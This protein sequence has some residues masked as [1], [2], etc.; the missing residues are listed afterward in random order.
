MKTPNAFREYRKFLVA[1]I[2]MA[3]LS[4]IGLYLPRIVKAGSAWGEWTVWEIRTMVG[5]APEGLEKTAE[6]WRAPMPDYALP[7][8]E[9]ASLPSLSVS[10]I[11]SGVIGMLCCGG[12]AWLV[13]RRLADKRSSSQ[14]TREHTR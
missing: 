1:M 9:N 13:G 8:Q 11:L 7:G 4:P 14:E 6:A 12:A 2:V 5:Y 3:L 10:Y